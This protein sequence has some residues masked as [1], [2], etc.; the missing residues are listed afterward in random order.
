MTFRYDER[1]TSLIE[2]GI[3]VTVIAIV[4]L[5][6]VGFVGEDTSV[7]FSEIRQGFP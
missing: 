7:M 5:V 3:L 2:W 1:G 6:A 4:A